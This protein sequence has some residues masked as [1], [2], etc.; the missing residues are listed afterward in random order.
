MNDK[1]TLAMDLFQEDRLVSMAFYCNVHGIKEG[2]MFIQMGSELPENA[3]WKGLLAVLTR[4]ASQYCNR[5]ILMA[6][7]PIYLQ[8]GDGR[9][10]DHVLRILHSFK[11][12]Q[13]IS[14][15]EYQGNLDKVNKLGLEDNHPI[16]VL[17]GYTI[18][19]YETR[20][21]GF[22]SNKKKKF[23][24]SPIYYEGV[25]M[26]ATG[27]C[28]DLEATSTVIQYARV[29]EYGVVKFTDGQ[30]TD[31]LQSFVN[32]N[33]KIPKAVREL[34]GITQRDVD[35]APRSYDAI[36]ALVY[37]LKD[38]RYLIGHNILYDFS[39]IDTFC[40]RFRLPRLNVELICT[41]R[42]AKKSNLIVKDY[43]METLLKLYDIH[44]ERPHRA[45]PDATA[46]FYLMKKMFTESF[47]VS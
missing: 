34:T 4:L 35:R 9:T 5:T 1:I 10:K 8:L 38:C 13:H 43:R 47:L 23:E 30:I 6:F 11:A 14:F 22:K 19:E 15:F 16:N 31:K 24:V 45:L 44:N 39:L 41:K 37:Y 25:F 29:I 21:I 28:L 42:L 3:I 26:P 20:L 18:S 32:P 27:A 46:N 17:R 12:S 36:K 33:M 2:Y 7:S 40:Q